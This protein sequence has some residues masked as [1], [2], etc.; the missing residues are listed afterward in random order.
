MQRLVIITIAVWLLAACSPSKREAPVEN[1]ADLTQVIDALR[2]AYA[3]FNRG[4][5]DAAVAALDPQIDWSEP[6]EFP[7]GGPYHG[8][9]EVKRYLTQSRA[10]WAEGSSEPERFITAGNRIVVFVH[11]RFRPKGTG[12]WQDV[13][14]ADVYTVRDGKI[15]AMRAFA[16]RDEAIRW[17]GA[18]FRH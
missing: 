12:D 17:A 16:D 7:G 2:S 1:K 5:M 6:A 10:G 18:I 15:V 8:R 4:D 3:A 13:K 11:A 14:L 9:D